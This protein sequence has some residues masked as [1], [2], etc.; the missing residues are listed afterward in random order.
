MRSKQAKCNRRQWRPNIYSIS[1][2]DHDGSRISE[3]NVLWTTQSCVSSRIKGLE[4]A[5]GILLFERRHRGVRLTEAGRH[6][7]AEISAGIAHLDHAV[8]IVV[9]R[10]GT[11]RRGP[12]KDRI[13]GLK[14][15]RDQATTDAERIQV[16]LDNAGSQSIATDMIHTLSDAARGSL[17]LDGGGYRRDHLRAFAQRV[18][19]AD[20][21]VRIMG[22]K[23]ELLQT[24]VAASRGDSAVLTVRSSV[25]KWCA[26]LDSNQRPP[27]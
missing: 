22:T 20:D 8:R 24:L 1:Y 12:F 15:I 10:D 5:L 6:F 21:E 23:S 11:R 7:V 9:R 18:E 2:Q 26:L 27:A 17:R 3:L 16:T 14:A 25:L 13:A 19:V 4:D